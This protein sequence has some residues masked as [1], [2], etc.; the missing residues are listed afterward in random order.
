[1]KNIV[2]PLPTFIFSENVIRF[3]TFFEKV[4]PKALR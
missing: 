2:M 4:P 3:F 1:M